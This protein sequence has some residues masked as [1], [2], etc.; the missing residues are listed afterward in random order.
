ME[1]AE[2]GFMERKP[3]T[4]DPW[5]EYAIEKIGT[6]LSTDQTHYEDQ[7][8]GC[9]V[10][11][12]VLFVGAGVDLYQMATGKEQATPW[13]MVFFGLAVVGFV[14]CVALRFHI[15]AV[16]RRIARHERSLKTYG[17]RHL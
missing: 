11:G 13:Q 8:G 9:W 15:S 6:L 12:V 2:D 10:Y 14:A 1:G 4:R 5:D 3:P 16:L 17:V 7:R